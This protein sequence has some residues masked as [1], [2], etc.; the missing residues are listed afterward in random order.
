MTSSRLPGFCR[1]TPQQR[2]DTLVSSRWIDP[3]EAILLKH[4]TDRSLENLDDMIENYLTAIPLPVG[5]VTNMRVNGTDRLV[6]VATEEPSVVAAA[7][8]AARI[9]RPSG[10]ISARAGAGTIDAHVLLRTRAGPD[11]LEHALEHTRPRLDQWTLR[12]HPR[13]S[14][15]GGGIEGVSIDKV[16][17]SAE[18]LF[19]IIITCRPADSMGANF[20]TEV[21]ETLAAMLSQFAP[22]E[23]IAAIVSNQPSGLPSTAE[24]AIDPAHLAW[25]HLPGTEVSDRIVLLSQWARVSPSRSATHAK[26]ILNGILGLLTALRQDTRAAGTTSLL[27]ALQNP[28]L[29]PG[30]DW[31]RSSDGLLRGRLTAH[32]PCGIVGGAIGSSA[33]TP[34]FL[35]L[36]HATSAAHVAEVACALG[37]LQN[38]SALLA[39]ATT[40]IHEPHI[41][42]HARKSGHH[43]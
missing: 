31:T 37:L 17:L 23:P 13:L 19:E 8:K 38:L 28:E 18:D 22:L 43:E 29:A 1:L 11:V 6:P 36:M 35:K 32:V 5:I 33:T 4:G 27:S 7:S 2:L 30:A 21:A 10:G 9:A 39:L 20:A 3:D 14:G 12:Q 24:V 42:L 16:S 25:E 40:G 15:A 41:R 34:I 26:G